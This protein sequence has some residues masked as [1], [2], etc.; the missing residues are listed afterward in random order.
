MQFGKFQPATATFRTAGLPMPTRENPLSGNLFRVLLVLLDEASVTRAAERLNLS[1]PATSLILK[2][3]RDIFGDPLLVRGR[4]GMV[5]TERA[6]ILR[7]YQ[8]ALP[9]LGSIS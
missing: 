5:L 3:L 4:G 8:S 6:E 1:Q 9:I 2:Q 7:R